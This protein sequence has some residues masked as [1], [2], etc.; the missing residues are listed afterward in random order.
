MHSDKSSLSVRVGHCHVQLT[1]IYMY[2][3][4]IDGEKRALFGTTDFH[5]GTLEDHVPAAV[6]MSGN[7][8]RWKSSPDLH[9]PGIISK[10]EHSSRVLERGVILQMHKSF[11]E[12]IAYHKIPIINPGHIF[13]PNFCW[14]YFWGSL[15]SEGLIIG[16]N[17]AF[18][19]A[20]FRRSLF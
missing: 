1:G 7:E 16:R 6:Q 15:F 11:N 13:A 19:W 14:A 3:F 8:R 9:W 2:N 20:Y 4:T 12:K 17:F 5:Y 10:Q 18:C